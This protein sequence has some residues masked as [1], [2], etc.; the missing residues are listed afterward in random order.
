LEKSTLAHFSRKGR[1]RNGAPGKSARLW[2]EKG[3]DI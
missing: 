2:S 3:L 1:T